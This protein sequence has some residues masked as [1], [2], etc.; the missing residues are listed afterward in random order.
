MTFDFYTELNDNNEDDSLNNICL[1]S[2]EPLIPFRSIT[3]NCDHSFDYINLFLWFEH[4]LF[5][6]SKSHS[7]FIKQCPYCRNELSHVLPYIPDLVKRKIKHINIGLNQMKSNTCTYSN[8]N[9]LCL[10]DFCKS[11]A[12]YVNLQCPEKSTVKQLRLY[13]KSI[14]LKRYS[15]LNKQKLIDYIQGASPPTANT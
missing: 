13:A 2:H 6:H 8:C 9:K 10:V 3:L 1:I 15:H 12:Q 14:H 4:E 7:P 5:R 11:H